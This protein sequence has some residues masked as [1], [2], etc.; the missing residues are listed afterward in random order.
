[1]FAWVAWLLVA[2]PLLLVICA[3]LGAPLAFIVG[4]PIATAVVYWQS[5]SKHATRRPPQ[6][7]ADGERP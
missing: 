3:A 4:W 5:W 1:M 2:S 6:D 7:E